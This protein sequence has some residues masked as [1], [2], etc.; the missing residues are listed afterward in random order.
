L[1]RYRLLLGTGI[2]AWV[3]MPLTTANIILQ[4]LLPIPMPKVI[5]LVPSIK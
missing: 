5:L 4:P 1:C 3:T 2:Y